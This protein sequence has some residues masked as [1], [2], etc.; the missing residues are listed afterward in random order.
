MSQLGH[1]CILTIKWVARGIQYIVSVCFKDCIV[2][3]RYR[4][5]AQSCYLQLHEEA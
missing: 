5:C 1:V 2:F 4:L 3:T